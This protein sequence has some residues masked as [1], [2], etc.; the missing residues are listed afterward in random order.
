M[1]PFITLPWCLLNGNSEILFVQCD[2]VDYTMLF[3]AQSFLLDTEFEIIGSDQTTS[4][5]FQ[6]KISIEEIDPWLI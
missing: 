6:E 4:F 3:D 5:A 1:P 2:G